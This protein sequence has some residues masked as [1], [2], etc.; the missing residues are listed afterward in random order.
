MAIPET[1]GERL[2]AA[3][4]EAGL[5]QKQ[6][7]DR[8]GL[9]R[10]TVNRWTTSKAPIP[11]KHFPIIEEIT[12]RSREWIRT[13]KESAPRRMPAVRE[14]APGPLAPAGLPIRI[15]IWL[16]EFLLT[17]T[18]LGATEDEIT[19]AR[20]LLTSPEL[21]TWYVGGYPEEFDEDQVLEG[22]K[23]IGV[24][25]ERQVRKRAKERAP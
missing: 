16:Q 8:L 11:E 22:M 17:I 9:A 3:I 14:R 5:T 15:R 18:R 19:R 13:G 10:L 6:V 7:A 2:A 23:A 4:E 24:F 20:A 1:P 12:G 21:S 25:I